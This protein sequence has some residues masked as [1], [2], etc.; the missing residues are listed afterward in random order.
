MQHTTI[1]KAISCHV[2]LYT[3]YLAVNEQ[4]D[5]THSVKKE[6]KDAASEVQCMTCDKI[7]NTLIKP[8]L[9]DQRARYAHVQTKHLQWNSIDDVMA[10]IYK[11]SVATHHSWN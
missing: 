4:W 7:R 10:N 6:K 9:F 11:F 5:S 1:S 3:Q 2:R 8:C